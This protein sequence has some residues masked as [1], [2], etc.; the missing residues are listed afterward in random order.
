MPRQA[1]LDMPGALHHVMGRGI[2][3]TNLFVD[4]LDRTDFLDRLDVLCGK[5]HLIVMAWALMP[6]H[7]HL[8]V[9]STQI[10]LSRSMRSL[11]T[12]YAGNF[13]RRHARVGHLFQNRF[14]S[15]LCEEEPYLLELVRYIHLNPLRAGLVG[16][17]EE[18]DR[19]P[20]TGH[21]VLMGNLARP[22]QEVGDV[23]SRFSKMGAKAKGAY[24]LFVV[25]GLKDKN[26][27][28]Y[29]GGGLRRS[30]G[31]WEA[32]LKMKRGRE[33]YLGDERILG[34]SDFVGDLVQDVARREEK[35]THLL[36]QWKVGELSEGVCRHIHVSL[37][38]LAGGGRNR[39]VVR[40]REGI[41]YLWI[42]HLNQNGRDLCRDTGMKPTLVYQAARRGVPHAKE[43]ED[44]LNKTLNNTK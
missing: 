11:M 25:E 17:V 20:W 38:S 44:F 24:R 37:E 6:N 27:H 16:S 18:L 4:D 8:L 33:N 15:V 2:A 23:L 21:S 34:G 9:R 35:K 1:R 13:N 30:Y 39:E 5:K 26:A 36:K 3:R 12:G 43:W 42:K 41:C 40:A 22:W 10:P 32:V 7:F 28:R 29:E 19:Y 31:G 14:K